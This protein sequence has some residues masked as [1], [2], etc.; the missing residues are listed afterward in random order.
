MSTATAPIFFSI[1][2]ITTSRSNRMAVIVPPLLL[3][4]KENL[5]YTDDSSSFGPDSNA[6]T[7]TLI[8]YLFTTS[9][10]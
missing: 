7:S 2:S 5:T 10:F 9:L 4:S 8:P 3:L 1:N 6:P